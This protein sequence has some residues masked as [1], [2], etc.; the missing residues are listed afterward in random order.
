MGTAIN[1]ANIYGV[2]L[3]MLAASEGK[4]NIV[5][6]LAEIGTGINTLDA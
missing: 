6:F 2:T 1:Y 5:C 3:L 4:L